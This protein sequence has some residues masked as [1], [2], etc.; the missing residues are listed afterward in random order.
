MSEQSPTG[1]GKAGMRVY[2]DPRR[3][4]ANGKCTYAAPGIFVIDEETGGRIAR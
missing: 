4:V 1:Q 2:V 3:C